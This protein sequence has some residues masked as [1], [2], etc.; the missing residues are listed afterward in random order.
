MTFFSHSGMPR[1]RRFQNTRFQHILEPLWL[2]I[3]GMANIFAF[4]KVK[5]W[6]LTGHKLFLKHQNFGVLEQPVFTLYGT[7][8]FKHNIRGILEHR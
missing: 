3:S 8:F 4:Q 7:A 6:P 2:P 1:N 5:H